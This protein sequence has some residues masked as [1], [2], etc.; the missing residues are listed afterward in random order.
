LM[1][2]N[3]E[4]VDYLAIGYRKRLGLLKEAAIEQI[5][6]RIDALAQPFE[7]LEHFHRLYLGRTA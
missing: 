7:T 3:P 6:E 2:L 4:Q 5:G 1:Q